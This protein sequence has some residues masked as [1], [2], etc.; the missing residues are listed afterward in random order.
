MTVEEA[1][2]Y[3]DVDKLTRNLLSYAFCGTD[4]WNQGVAVLDKTE[5]VPRWFWINWDMDRSFWFQNSKQWL[6]KDGK[7]WRKSVMELILDPMYTEPRAVVCLRLLEDDPKYRDYFISLFMGLLNHQL[8]SRFFS[9]RI[10]YYSGLATAY[11]KKLLK[12]VDLWK[13]FLR[14]RPQFIRQE[15]RKYFGLG[16]SFFCRVTGPKGIRFKIDG[17]LEES[18]YAGW[19][20]KDFPI[21]VEVTDSLPKIFS[22]WRV[23]GKR[24][25][26]DS[27]R[28]IVH[29][30]TT[31]TPVFE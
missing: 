13:Q 20:F 6:E 28:Y 8:N 4:D 26:G 30:E 11:K 3:V 16:P 22:H 14:R 21:T 9:E 18:S 24:I 10:R 27:L 25:T 7:T 31:I 23:N 1:E 5:T 17:Y 12:S 2:K 19:Y 29:S 15:M